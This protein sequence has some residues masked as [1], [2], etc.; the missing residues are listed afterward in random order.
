MA[1][2]SKLVLVAGRANRWRLA[3]PLVFVG[4]ASIAVPAGFE[5]DLASVPRPFRNLFNV[6]GKSRRAAVLHDWLYAGTHCYTRKQA[7]RIFLEA[8]QSDGVGWAERNAMFSAVRAFGWA[9][10]KKCREQ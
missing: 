3:R 1:F 4:S 8:M 7:D 5:T 9:Y 6:N 2:K 10:F